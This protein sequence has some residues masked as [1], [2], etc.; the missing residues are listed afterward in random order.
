MAR[1][2]HF[3]KIYRPLISVALLYFTRHV[4]DIIL[5]PEKTMYDLITSIL[6]LIVLITW[7]IVNFKS[8]IHAPKMVIIYGLM[9]C[10]LTNLAVRDQLPYW[11]ST[12]DKNTV[13]DSIFTTLVVCHCGNYNTMMVTFFIQC[14]IF[15]ISYYCQLLK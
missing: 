11:M 7:R 12:N 15:L 3:N 1:A 9:H 10:I 13:N 6:I 5:N 8:P 4:I 2:I 14:P